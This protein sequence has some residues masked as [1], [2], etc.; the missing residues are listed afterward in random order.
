MFTAANRHGACG[1]VFKKG[2][3]ELS[4]WSDEYQAMINDRGGVVKEYETP[5][6][7][8]IQYDAALGYKLYREGQQEAMAAAGTIRRRTYAGDGRR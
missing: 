6:R 7:S 4:D 2:R 8:R 5:L 1:R 3:V